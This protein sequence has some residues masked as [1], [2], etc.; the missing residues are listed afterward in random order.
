MSDS[1]FAKPAA[2][3]ERRT[4]RPATG[5]RAYYFIVNTVLTLLLLAVM[6]PLVY[7]VSA[8]FSSP[9]AVSAGKVFLWP[10]DFSLEGYK[11]VFKS[12][13]I[14]SG[15]MNTFLYTGVG[16]LINVS[17]TMIAAYPLS[18]RDLPGRNLFML[19]FTFTMVFNAGMIPMYILMKNL[20]FINT[21]WA[22]V[23]PG[24]ISVYN[25][26]ITRT[27]IQSNIPNELLEASVIDGCSDA[28]YFTSILLPLSKSV[29]AVIT[30]F[31][32]VG[33]WNAY[34]NAFLYLSDRKL[35]PLQIVLRD[36]L[37]ANTIDVSTVIDPELQQAKQGLADLLKFSLIIVSSVPVLMLYPFIQK[38]FV[39]GVM[40][41][42]VKG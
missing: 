41:G 30:L 4:I 15:Y 31:Y 29:L 24:A 33:H 25:M 32:A 22:M 26:I 11:A 6:Y 5:D 39:R 20:N 36:I 35:F 37:V 27:Y 38:H 1:I 40:I 17:M 7:I 34:F 12:K 10:V 16:T 8:S 21:I 42:S 19:L 2:L 23:I 28:R 9:L 13:D 18:R 3:G 14:L